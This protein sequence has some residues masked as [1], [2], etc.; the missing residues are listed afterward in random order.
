MLGINTLLYSSVLYQMKL[1]PRTIAVMGLVGA[2]SIFVA[3]LLEMFG[4]IL[5]V[6]AWG[7]VLSLPVAIY[8]MTLAVYL[9]VK[10][11]KS[12]ALAFE[13]ANMETGELIV[14]PS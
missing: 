9:I 3:A 5:Q 14:S 7:A 11:F 12:D 13:S 10:G 4:V 6:S 2:V 8:E 1:F